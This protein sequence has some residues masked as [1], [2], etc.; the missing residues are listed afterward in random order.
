MVL[1]LCLSQKQPFNHFLSHLTNMKKIIILAI[2]FI[3]FLIPC[4]AQRKIKGVK[5]KPTLSSIK[6]IGKINQEL[7]SVYVTFENYGKYYWDRTKQTY[8]IAW[9]RLHNNFRENI[10]FCYYDTSV[11]ATG[12]IGVHYEIEKSPNNADPTSRNNEDIPTGFIP[13]D[14]CDSYTL[15]SG[16]NFLFGIIQDHLIKDTRIKIHFYYS[17]EDEL[18]FGTVKEPQHYVYFYANDLPTRK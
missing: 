1:Y 14:V 11:S 7:P 18:D 3:L 4:L 9:F 6:R 10:S 16:K 12:K 5:K 15:K 8:D 17:W 2:I 13:F